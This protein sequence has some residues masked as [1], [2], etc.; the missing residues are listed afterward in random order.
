VESRP[1]ALATTRQV[2]PWWPSV[3]VA[4][5][6]FAGGW[7]A[8]ALVR[9]G[10]ESTPVWLPAGI[11][12]AAL[13][14]FGGAALPGVWLGCFAF[15]ISLLGVHG[16]ATLAQGSLLAAGIA[17]ARL[18]GTS[19]SV[20]LG[21]W[22]VKQSP[23]G[24]ELLALTGALPGS[25]LAAGV[26]T[27]VFAHLGQ[28]EVGALAE[29]F[30]RLWLADV[31]GVFV[32]APLLIARLDASRAWTAHV[33]LS[34]GVAAT[35]GVVHVLYTNE[36]RIAR[37]VIQQAVDERALAIQ[38][39]FSEVL[40]A[41]DSL[42]AFFAA[43][44]DIYAA[45]FAAY[46]EHTL[47]RM[48]ALRALQW[49]PRVPAGERASHEAQAARSG[50]ADYRIADPVDGALV[51]AAEREAYY[52]LRFV[53]PLEPNADELGFD[54]ATCP[55]RSATL[56]RA[57][58]AR[59]LAVSPAL[60]ADDGWTLM[61]ALPVFP[62]GADL[63][64][65]RDDSPQGFVAALVHVGDLVENA[66]ARLDETS[67]DSLVLERNDEGVDAVLHAHA[68]HTRE[69]PL[70][71]D[72][73]AALLALRPGDGF[74]TSVPL[75]DRALSV[76]SAPTEKMRASLRSWTP[77]AA[78][79]AGWLISA[80]LASWLSSIAGR[81]RRVETLV[82]ERTA[83]LAAANS[84]K[85]AFLANMSHE[86]RTPMTAILGYADALAEDGLREEERPEI[87]ETIRRNGRRLLA[88]L[89]DVLDVSKIEAGRLDV[90]RMPCSLVEQVEETLSLLRGRAQEKGLALSVDYL[91]PLPET[92]SSDAGRLRQILMNLVSNAIKFTESGGVRLTVFA[93]EVDSRAARV[94]VEVVD[95]GIGIAAESLPRLFQPFVQA[96]SSMTRRFGGTG[97]GLAI[98][99]R[100]AQMLGGDIEVASTPG[101]GSRFHLWLDPGPLAGVRLLHA[102]TRAADTPE[103]APASHAPAL[104][105]R[106][107]LAE[108]THDTRVLLRHVL[109]RAGLAVEIAENGREALEKALASRAADEPFDVVLMDMQMPVLDGYD[110]T[111]ALRSAGYTL[112]IVALTAHTMAGE[113][114]KCLAVG[115]D[116]YASKPI[117]RAL[118]LAV[119]RRCL[120]KTAAT[121]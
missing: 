29:S 85:T 6:C 69:Q 47:A 44:D 25:G 27:A 37:T 90:E 55:K 13:R 71:E 104:R 100:L 53:A 32:I 62:A 108:D 94:H 5:A 86:V 79:A 56:E 58:D 92:I 76:L 8:I 114:E 30:A 109:T 11:A 91:F 2:W 67:I 21:R 49:L 66:L 80:L 34:L 64:A 19:S 93:S 120:E 46:A 95:D 101:A 7:L 17:T 33:A 45:R 117:D 82:L 105:G 9:A 111:R 73:I 35:L 110:A 26:A 96:D 68:A 28:I 22:I 31:A 10:A 60:R 12:L 116:D 74:R 106:V 121:G 15:W 54:M 18:L 23:G 88:I 102:P 113:R 57:G 103:V 51:A 119:V 24:G 65:T 97:L 72:E 83:E 118:L 42:G 81:T 3:L 63:S 75:G 4:A 38:A 14:L 77:L 112:P 61:V 48:P 98:S 40:E 36:A 99:K 20:W 107:L 1:L 84:A 87:V 50:M 78:L 41:V 43:S 59:D 115:C 39:D 89:D 52:P 16:D 70:G